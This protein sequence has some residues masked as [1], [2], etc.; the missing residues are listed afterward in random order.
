MGFDVKQR[1]SAAIAVIAIG[2]F[3]AFTLEKG[4]ASSTT[5]SAPEPVPPI[6]IEQKATDSTCSNV[7]ADRDAKVDCSPGLENKDA[8]THSTK[9][10]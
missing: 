10:H 3:V 6:V 2:C 4:A 1:I 8:T 9:K 5:Q 7:I